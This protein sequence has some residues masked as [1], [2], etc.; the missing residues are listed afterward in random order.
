[1]KRVRNKDKFFNNVDLVL[2]EFDF[3]KVHK[4]MKALDWKW[5]SCNGVPS[6]Q[7]L[8]DTARSLL[9]DLL[10]SDYTEVGTGGFTAV[11]HSFKEVELR[12]CIDDVDSFDY[13]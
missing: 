7:N 10:N 11:R 1:M 12:F 6:K 9:T 5:N 3:D 2:Q 13:K 8:K 4:A